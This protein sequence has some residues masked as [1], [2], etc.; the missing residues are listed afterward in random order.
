MLHDGASRRNRRRAI[1]SLPSACLLAE[2][3]GTGDNIAET[4]SQASAKRPVPGFDSI[5][6]ADRESR[7]RKA[8]APFPG[9]IP[10]ECSRPRD[11][12]GVR[13]LLHL[14]DSIENL[15]DWRHD[16]LESLYLVLSCLPRQFQRDTTV[17]YVFEE[18]ILPRSSIPGCFVPGR[19][20][21]IGVSQCARACGSSKQRQESCKPG[22]KRGRRIPTSP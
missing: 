15:R 21:S 5:M 20:A 17:Q 9:R 22:R 3:R 19:L 6:T 12:S 10:W 11:H 16:R 8:P 2:Y 13:A 18:T 1:N 7:S 4:W 14:R